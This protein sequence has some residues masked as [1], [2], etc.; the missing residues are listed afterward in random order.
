MHAPPNKRTT[1]TIATTD[2]VAANLA[3]VSD[4]YAAFGRGDIPAILDRTAPGCRWEAWAHNYAQ[5]AGLS[6]LQPRVGPSEVAEFFVAVGQ[7]E[8]HAFDLLDLIASERQVVAEVEIEYTTPAGRRMRDEE[9]HLWALDEAQQVV[10]MR[11]YVDTAKHIAAFAASEE[12]AALELNKACARRFVFEHNQAAFAATFDEVLA[13]GCTLHEYLP[14]VPTAMD[15]Q[16]YEQFI[17]MFRSALPDIRNVI[18]D[19]AAED[20]RVFVRWTGRGTHTGDA[21]MGIPAKGSQLTAHGMYVF[22]MEGGKIVEVWDNWD[23][24][25]M[26]QQLG[27]LPGSD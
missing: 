1:L 22:C 18:E 17:A 7:L 21:L 26:L 13:P 16:A 10:C 27:G 9:L 3:T 23:N 25:N 5:L 11:H 15:R 24:L 12:S 8:L 6:T 4:I 20:D 14:G 2:R 19:V